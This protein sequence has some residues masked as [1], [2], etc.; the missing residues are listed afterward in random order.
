M[1]V[2]VYATHNSVREID[3]KDKIAV[4]VDVL[5]ATS[6]IVTSL[7]SGCKEVIPVVEIEEAME[8]SRNYERESYLLA[9]ERNALKIEGFDLSNSPAEYVREVVED[10]SIIFT[11]TNGTKAIRR[12]EGAKKVILGALINAEAVSDYIL[13][14]RDDVA[15]I[16]AGTEGRFSLDDILA[17]G[18][19]IHRMDNGEH[20]LE[21]DDLAIVCRYMYEQHSNNLDSIMQKS[22]HYNV[23]EETEY[24]EDLEYCL[25]EDIISIVPE[26]IDGVLKATND[27]F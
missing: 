4:V 19:I 12:A 25:K 10:K 16:C 13:S 14:H 18:S 11:T 17:V 3:I 26:Y 6:T 20:S 8:I 24:Y 5:R 9:G 1:K 27:N 21:F 23:L 22:R 15:F 2:N 7:N